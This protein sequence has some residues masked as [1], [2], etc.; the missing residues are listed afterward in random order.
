MVV[1]KIE[2]MTDA[3]KTEYLKK[4]EERRLKQI[5]SAKKYNKKITNAEQIEDEEEKKKF[6]E[7]KKKKLE[8]NRA[9]YKKM[10]ESM[11]KAENKN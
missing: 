10:R 6:L 1:K 4:L 9:Y 7:L 2:D 11:K 8:Y 5:E 3:E